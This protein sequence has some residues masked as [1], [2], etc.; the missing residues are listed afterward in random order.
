MSEGREHSLSSQCLCLGSP[1]E[2]HWLL[3]V[4]LRRSWG[5]GGD[6]EGVL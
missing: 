5:V 4:R 2:P 6:A 1:I 3:S